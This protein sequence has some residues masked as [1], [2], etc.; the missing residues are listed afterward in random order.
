MIVRKAVRYRLETT[1][2]QKH[3]LARAAG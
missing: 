2:E 1:P 3:L